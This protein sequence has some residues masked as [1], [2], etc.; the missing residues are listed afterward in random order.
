MNAVLVV[1]LSRVLDES[2]P[3]KRGAAALQARFDAA[4]AQHEKLR[5][6]GTTERGKREADAAATAFET[7]AVQELERER[8]KLRQ[9]VLALARPLIA[10]LMA[11]RKAAIVVDAAACLAIAAA[12]DVTDDV[13]KR[14]GP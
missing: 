10:A 3:G 5:S 6:R 1:D 14:L 7:E 4:R 2:A 9:E 13:V 8:A 11:E 12:V